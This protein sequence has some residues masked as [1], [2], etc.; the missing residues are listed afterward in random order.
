MTTSLAKEKEISRE[1]DSDRAKIRELFDNS[2]DGIVICDFDGRFIEYNKKALNIF[3][4]SVDDFDKLCMADLLEKYEPSLNKS[5]DD[6]WNKANEG[7]EVTFECIDREDSGQTISGLQINLRQLFWQASDVIF[8]SL[9]DITA[10][11]RTEDAL[12]LTKNILA[13]SEGYFEAVLRN[14]EL[15]I[16]CKDLNGRYLAVNA[17]FEELCGV[18]NDEL[19]GALDADIFPVNVANFLNFR[20]KEITRRHRSIELEQ[21]F[22]LAGVERDLLIHKFPL[23]ESDGTV[24]GIAGICTDVST[25][26]QAL[27][28]A[29]STNEAKTEFLARMSHELRTP[30][31]SILGVARLG[32]RKVTDSPRDKLESYFKMIISSGDKLLVL[33]AN[34]LDLSMLESPH[35]AYQM[36]TG[37][38]SDDLN[39][40]VSEFQAVMLEKNVVLIYN[41]PHYPVIVLY[42]KVKMFQV[43]RNLI[44]NAL[45]FSDSGKEI[46]IDICKSSLDKKTTVLPAWKIDVMDRGIG[47]EP[48]EAEV[49]FGKFFQGSKTKG[50]GGVGLGL[51]ICRQIVADH[52]GSIW[53]EKNV[54]NGATFSVLLPAADEEAFR[55]GKT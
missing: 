13:R 15:P 37:D 8:V 12:A 34:L 50:S 44:Y 25:M 23:K 5:F 17:P 41:S 35:T 38:L 7:E 49:I 55:A 26:K 32:L 2:G 36:Q 52:G 19:K 54:Y 51:S 14:L 33:L 43:F 20:D 53:G 39:E 40:I 24:Y 22:T 4:C 16:Y 18:N 1:V 45:K 10:R 30:M 11:K 48:D 21:T 28:I 47:I 6:L 29:Q 9:R 3:S 42:D 31:H 27:R 46:R